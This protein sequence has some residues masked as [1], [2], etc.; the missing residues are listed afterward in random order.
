M[1]NVFCSVWSGVSTPWPWSGVGLCTWISVPALRFG[2]KERKGRLLFSLC[3]CV[4][5]LLLRVLCGERTMCIIIYTRYARYACNVEINVWT[6]NGKS[7][8]LAFVRAYGQLLMIRVGGR[9]GGGGGLQMAEFEKWLNYGENER[10]S[11]EEPMKMK[12][13]TDSPKTNTD[14][15]LVDFWFFSGSFG[16]CWVRLCGWWCRQSMVDA[17]LGKPLRKYANCRRKRR[18]ISLHF[19]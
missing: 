9:G 13:W 16:R 5:A 12:I 7:M 14:S 3:V 2:F 15:R 17:C 18:Y 6:D 8:R 19:H 10:A 11:N 4:A 1:C